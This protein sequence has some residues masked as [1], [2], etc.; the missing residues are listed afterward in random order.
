DEIAEPLGIDYHIGLP[1]AHHSRCA[2]FIA[3]IEGSFFDAPDPTSLRARALAQLPPTVFN[4]AECRVTEIAAINGHGTAR[5]VAH[6]YGILATGG[7][8]AGFRLL[9]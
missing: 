5:A 2:D 7:A 4:D 8:S 3:V 1:Q 9:S 6:V